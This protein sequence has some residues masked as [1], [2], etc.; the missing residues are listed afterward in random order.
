[1]RQQVLEPPYPVKTFQ[2]LA[3]EVVYR[4]WRLKVVSIL[5]LRMQSPVQSTVFV[6]PEDPNLGQR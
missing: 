4:L 3:S 2:G 1:M 6:A 5:R